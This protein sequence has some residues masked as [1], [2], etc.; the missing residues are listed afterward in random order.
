M[1][2]AITSELRETFGRKTHTLRTEGRIPAVLYGFEVEPQNITL[3][4]NELERLYREAGE[5]TVVTL[6]VDSAEHNVLIQEIQRDPV[7]D[8]I[9]H[10]DFR[11]IDM[12]Q[13]VEASILLTLAGEAP[14]VKEL[15][16]VIMR[17]LEEVDV[18]A[19]PSALVR[20]LEVDISALATFDDVIRV[21]DL[22]APAGIEIL[23]EVETAVASVQPPRTQEEMDA[24]DEAVVED[25]DA[26]EV[27]GE[28]K[29]GEEEAEGEADGEKKEK[30]EE[31]K[32]PEAKDGE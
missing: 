29:E 8:L 5:S 4:R 30:E 12:S 23:T 20:E 22:T 11:R 32:K 28:T 1:T 16:G 27:E 19:L 31:E 6:S 10:A 17:T 2:F 24:L 25:V 18:L 9:I 15:G 26:V 13:K 7:S 14:A 21:K 3:D